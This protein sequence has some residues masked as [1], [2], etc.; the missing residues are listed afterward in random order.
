[1]KRFCVITCEH[2]GNRLPT[3]FRPLF[4]RR[5]QQLHSH[6]GWDRGAL[7]LAREMAAALGGEHHWSVVSRLLVDL[8]R[9]IGAPDNFSDVTATLDSATRTE[10]LE[11]YYHP[12]RRSVERSVASAIERGERVL[13]LSCHSFAEEL[14]GQVRDSQL[15]ILYDPVRLTEQRL[16]N[17]WKEALKHELPHADPRLN[18]P[19][20]GTDDGLVTTLRGRYPDPLYAGIELEVRR[21]VIMDAGVRHKLIKTL[22]GLLAA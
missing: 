9:S 13:H 16:A 12:Y 3:R 14:D 11:Q 4:A 2:G 1:M 10:I 17:G 7:R 21:D 20:L 18:Y 22:A 5:W 6:D 15:G 8:N 19:Y